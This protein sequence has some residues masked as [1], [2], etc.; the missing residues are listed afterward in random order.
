MSLPPLD[1][2]L[3]LPALEDEQRRLPSTGHFQ[4]VRIRESLMQVLAAT[5][6]CPAC[7]ESSH[8]VEEG[9]TPLAVKA[10]GVH[11]LMQR[12]FLQRRTSRRLDCST[13]MNG[14]ARELEE[15]SSGKPQR[16][17][18]ALGG[19]GPDLGR[20]PPRC[21]GRRRRLLLAALHSLL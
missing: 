3:F 17:A 4:P 8:S 21:A 16:A 1:I 5:R 12:A 6:D 11:D 10:V 7:L 14:L 18:G 19:A 13:Y 15:A 9:L 2:V 20:A